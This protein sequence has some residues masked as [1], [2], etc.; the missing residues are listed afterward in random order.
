MALSYVGSMSL[1]ALSPVVYASMGQAAVP[2]N[3]A[4]QGNLA[5]KA[6]LETSPPTL[7]SIVAAAE[8]FQTQLDLALASIPPVPSVSFS[9]AD[10]VSLTASL[11]ASVGLMSTLTAL[12]GA[13]A[14]I[15]SFAYAGPANA[16]G[17]A[18][19]TEL[20]ST[21]PDGAPT[22]SATTAFVFGATTTISMQQ[23][24]AFLNA[25]QPS[26]GLSYA[27]RLS[28]GQLSEVT[29]SAAPQGNS[30]LSVQLQATAALQASLAA[31]PTPPSF[32]S[33]I[34]NEAKFLRNLA[35]QPAVPDVNLAI[36][37]AANAAANLQTKFG[38]LCQL[39]AVLDRF[40]ATVFVYSYVGTAA[41]LGDTVT[42][43]LA[44]T[45]PDGSPTSGECVAAILGSTDSV[46]TS[47]MS[48]FFGGA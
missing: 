40:D 45:W 43:A 48:A 4:L 22:S 11:N 6:S 44:S 30:G 29:A 7:A 32:P 5:L 15:Y 28:L 9:I 36:A 35:A 19:T 46:T 41:A 13:A 23:L 26:A 47:A 8:E 25:L 42:S 34:A 10:C 2:M 37:A 31:T 38:A 20:A 12:L 14:A 27:G 3:A 33:M 21:W 17:A 1:A 39:G 18:L 16:M 24:P